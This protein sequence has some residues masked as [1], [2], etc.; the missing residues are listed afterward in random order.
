MNFDSSQVYC[1]AG[2]CFALLRQMVTVTGVD[3]LT[4]I[5]GVKAVRTVT[6]SREMAF[7]CVCVCVFERR[8]AYLFF[9]L[10]YDKSENVMIVQN[11]D[12]S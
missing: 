6:A 12:A 5:P 10:F 3:M 7:E 9:Y 4:G 8:G 11:I 2:M 1:C